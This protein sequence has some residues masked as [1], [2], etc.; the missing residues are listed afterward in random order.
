MMVGKADAGKGVLGMEG[1]MAIFPS[2]ELSSFPSH[3]V[4]PISLPTSIQAG[5]RA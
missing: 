4:T 2:S 3:F 1:E 5:L